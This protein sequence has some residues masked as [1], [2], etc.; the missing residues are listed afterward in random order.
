MHRRDA[1]ARYSA[2][3]LTPVLAVKYIHARVPGQTTHR[4]A[5]TLNFLSCGKAQVGSWYA[6]PT[7]A[8]ALKEGF[9]MFARLLHRLRAVAQAAAQ[10][11]RRRL[12]AA[13]RPVTAPL[14][15][16]TLTLSAAGRSSL[17]RMRSCGSN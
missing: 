13:T 7:P 14:I 8:T 10:V 11:L 17:P 12:L 9:V 2:V 16:G 4:S 3:S 1:L 15:A 6:T 5:G